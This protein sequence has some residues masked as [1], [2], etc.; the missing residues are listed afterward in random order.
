[1]PYIT[2]ELRDQLDPAIENLTVAL[3][4][5]TVDGKMVHASEGMYNYII[6]KLLSMGYPPT[7]GS[8]NAAI[9]ILECAKMEF[10]RRVAG[11]YEDTKISTNGDVYPAMRIPIDLSH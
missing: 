2:Q 11:P 5:V 8:I 9:G 7:Y 4:K 3:L 6:T 1:M 10:Y